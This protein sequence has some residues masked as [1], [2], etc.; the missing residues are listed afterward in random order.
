MSFPVSPGEIDAFAEQTNKQSVR[1]LPAIFWREASAPG[2]AQERA[3]AMR[4]LGFVLG[5]G[6]LPPLA[7]LWSAVWKGRD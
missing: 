4:L 5:L 3:D 1:H 2:I 6:T 7:N